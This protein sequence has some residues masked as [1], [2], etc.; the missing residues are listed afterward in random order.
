V[1]IFG[2]VLGASDVTNV[3]FGAESVASI[4]SQ[5]ATQVV[6]V[7]RAAAVAGPCNI[8]TVSTSY[9]VAR[10]PNGYVYNFGASSIDRANVAVY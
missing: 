3:S 4:V 1:T 8:T 9:G 2:G 10:L 5:T 7:T 6:V